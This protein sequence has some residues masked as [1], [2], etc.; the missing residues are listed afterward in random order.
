MSFKYEEICGKN[1]KELSKILMNRI[2]EDG[3]NV[4]IHF[5]ADEIRRT[6]NR[7]FNNQMAKYTKWMTIM[8][9]IILLATIA[10]M[11]VVFGGLVCL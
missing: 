2:K 10:N 1:S 11:I 9:G 7:E 3:G 8:T 5:L 4:S 6:E